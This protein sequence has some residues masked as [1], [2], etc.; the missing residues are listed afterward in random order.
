MVVLVG[1]DVGMDY[2]GVARNGTWEFVYK[3][4]MERYLSRD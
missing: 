1:K 2:D 4:E 3:S